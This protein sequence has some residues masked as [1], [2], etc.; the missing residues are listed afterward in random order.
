MSTLTNELAAIPTTPLTIQRVI[1]P[2]PH[3]D[4]NVYITPGQYGG[5]LGSQYDPFVLHA[6]PNAANFKVPNIEPVQG[7]S[8]V[9]ELVRSCHE[10]WDG[11]GYPRG[12]A[13]EQI[14]LGARII[15]A[16]DAYH[17]MTE[18]RSY[19]PALSGDEARRRLRGLA[20]S[21]FDPEVVKVYGDVLAER[22]D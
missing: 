21:H 16:C 8:G 9:A 5:M 20:G 15:L 2:E 19:Q 6:D 22:R 18:E 17:A 12:L 14:P 7:L 10:H 11:G 13:G 4:S 3:C 1:T